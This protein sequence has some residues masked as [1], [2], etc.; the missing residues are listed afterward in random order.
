MRM[1][2][3]PCRDDY[4]SQPQRTMWFCRWALERD[5]W[6]YLFK[7]DDDTYISIPR[8]LAYNQS[9]RDYIGSEWRP[10]VQY[11]S[12]GAG[13]FL[14]RKAAEIVAA[15]LP[16]IGSEDKL[17]GRM[18]RKSGLLFS[19]EPRLVPYGSSAKRPKR[20]NNLITAH[21]RKPDIFFL[22][23]SETGLMADAK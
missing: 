18:L 5:D 6:E 9:G 21:S 15:G 20:D 11:G 1:L 7:C 2:A 3:L 8:L 19:N 23:H 10:G 12:G 14:S 13:Y 4:R 22:S 16:A 17:V